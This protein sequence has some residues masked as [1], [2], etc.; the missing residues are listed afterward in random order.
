MVYEAISTQCL[1]LNIKIIDSARYVLNCFCEC[2]VV[3]II[4]NLASVA[5]ICVL[6]SFGP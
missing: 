2:S 3:I 6:D 4:A 5:I 1:G